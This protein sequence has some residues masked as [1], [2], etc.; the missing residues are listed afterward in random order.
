MAI[1]L[2]A[3]IS[4]YLLFD[5]QPAMKTAIVFSEPTAIRNSTPTFKSASTIRSPKG[6]TANTTMVGTNTTMGASQ[7]S[8]RSALRVVIGSLNSSFRASATGCS[9]PLGPTRLGPIRF[10]IRPTTRR[11]IQINASTL[12][13]VQRRIASTPI[14]PEMTYG[15]QSGAPQSR[16]CSRSDPTV[17]PKSR[18]SYHSASRGIIRPPWLCR[19]CPDDQR[20]Q[21]LSQVGGAIGGRTRRA[22]GLGVS[23]RLTIR[24]GGRDEGR[25]VW[26]KEEHYLPRDTGGRAHFPAPISPPSS[27]TVN[28]THDNV[29]APEDHNRVRHCPSNTHQL[30]WRQIDVRRRPD[31]KAK[32]GRTAVTDEVESKLATGR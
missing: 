5:D 23:S 19:C 17:L 4:A 12:R 16:I 32:W 1:V 31:M 3:P 14:N 8:M 21:S 29:H 15:T 25:F 27:S 26:S 30:Q 28:L 7:N 10:C 6:I 24:A 13:M 9:S 11:S 22:G 18:K 20:R 2:M